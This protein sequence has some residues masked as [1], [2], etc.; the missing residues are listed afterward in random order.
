MEYHFLD[1]QFDLFYQ[2]DN[3]ANAIFQIGAGLSI[4]IACLGLLG[5]V[6][7]TVQK[8]IK[9]LGIRK[10]LGASEWGLFYLLSGSF[11][12]QVLLA[13]LIASPIAFYLMKNWLDNFQYRVVIGFGVFIW[14]ALITLVIAIL[15]VSYRSFTAAHSNP[16]DSLRS[17]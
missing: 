1:Q 10:V 7:F 12:K 5:L 11:V 16:V 9:E 3:Q 2:K 17:E 14:A 4:F 8:R 15:T 6:S 13:F